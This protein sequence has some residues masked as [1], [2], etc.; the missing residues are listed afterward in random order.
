MLFWP[1][2]VTVTR[3]SIRPI[4]SCRS[5]RTTAVARSTT[6]V[7]C[8][9]LKPARLASIVYVPGRRSG[10][11]KLPPASDIVSRETEVASSVTAMVAPGTI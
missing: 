4:S 1:S 9:F 2:A 7:R 8:T 11:S 5:A 6:L 10:T 3:S